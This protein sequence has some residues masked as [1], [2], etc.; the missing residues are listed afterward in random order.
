MG[1]AEIGPDREGRDDKQIR[2][3]TTKHVSRQRERSRTHRQRNP[4]RENEGKKQIRTERNLFPN[5]YTE[6]KKKK[7]GKQSYI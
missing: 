2:R 7:K 4:D 3:H 1:R 6:E 5:R